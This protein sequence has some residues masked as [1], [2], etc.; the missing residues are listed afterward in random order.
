[1]A[2][3]VRNNVEELVLALAAAANLNQDGYVNNPANGLF[4]RDVT[5]STSPIP[6]FAEDSVVLTTVTVS[7]AAATTLPTTVA[8]VNNIFGVLQVHM[9]DNQ[10]HLIKD[11]YN[12]AA[13]VAFQSVPA[14]DLPS[15]I[16]L[17]NELKVVFNDHLTQTGVHQ[18]NDEVN[19]C[20]TAAATDL[21]SA[22]ALANALKSKLNSHMASAPVGSPR[23]RVISQ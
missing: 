1:M 10:V 13:L 23:V 5:Q 20:S 8:L 9:A 11:G 15:S 6:L 3:S 16:A 18:N 2:I 21:T 22:E 17:V 12:L 7:A 14:V 19:T 4:H